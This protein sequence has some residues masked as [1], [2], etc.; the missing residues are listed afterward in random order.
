MAASPFTG[1]T[2]RRTSPTV[3]Q[4]VGTSQRE[5]PRRTQRTRSNQQPP[6]KQPKGRLSRVVVASLT[7][8]LLAA[9]VL[10]AMPFIPPEPSELTGAVLCGFALGWAILG[11][12]SLRFTDQPQRWAWTPAVVMGL[13]GLSLIAFGPGAHDALGWVWPPVALALSVWMLTRIRR[14]MG[15]RFGRWLL[16]PLVVL[17][18]VVSVG[19]GTETVLSRTAPDYEMPGQLVDVGGHR[20]HLHCTGTG[21]PTV[22]LEPGAGMSSSTMGWIQPAVARD[23]RVCVY[24]RAGRGWSDP[25][26]TTQD[27]TQIAT[28]LHTL[29]Q[30]ANV[31]GPYVLAGHS[32]GGLYALTYAAQYPTEVAGMVLIDSTA[33]ESA[34]TSPT[35]TSSSYEQY[36]TGASGE[37]VLLGRL[38]REVQSVAGFKP[39]PV[40]TLG[41]QTFAGTATMGVETHIGIGALDHKLIVG[42]T[43]AGYDA[44]PEN[45]TKLV[46]VA[47]TQGAT[48]KR[49]V[50]P[51]GSR[52]VRRRP[53]GIFW[54][55]KLCQC[56]WRTDPTP[57]QLLELLRDRLDA[58]ELGGVHHRSS[59]SGNLRFMSPSFGSQEIG[60]VYFSPSPPLRG[61]IKT[62]ANVPAG[63][64]SAATWSVPW[65]GLAL[66][67]SMTPSAEHGRA[68][69]HRCNKA[70]ANGTCASLLR[71]LHT[72]R[73]LS[74]VRLAVV[75]PTSVTVSVPAVI[76]T[77]SSTSA[78]A[79]CTAS[80]SANM[81]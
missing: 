12:L 57:K 29:L 62:T 47:R 46:A 34:P 50:G 2:G 67:A 30:R 7:S 39:V 64:F 55:T 56:S 58:E 14:D 11:A 61:R 42:A 60:T 74:T 51:S 26:D 37:P 4:V 80:K 27:A 6:S 66:T 25:A 53:P 59:G 43:L 21:S 5:T 38:F 32:F 16:Y 78:A 63:D 41:Q 35:S 70:P 20:L 8:G 44:T 18:A 1:E 54:P 75:M 23:T 73:K 71:I 69:P 72:N 19:A 45:T 49:A 24:D 65:P 48:A 68:R 3:T 33:P 79:F 40:P 76:T 77:L 31:P 10:A 36:R 15:S 9:G 17:L 28:D 52:A 81:V 22:V 13:G